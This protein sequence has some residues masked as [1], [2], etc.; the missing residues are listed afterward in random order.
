MKMFVCNYAIS[1][2]RPYR[3]TGEFINVGVVLVCPQLDYFNFAFERRKHRRIT[4]FFPELDIEIFKT[5]LAGLLSELTRLAKLKDAAAQ[6][7][8]GEEMAARMALF[9]ELVRPRENLFHFGEVGTAFTEDPKTKLK[10]L[11]DIYVRRQFAQDHEYQEIVMRR[12]LAVFL[13]DA[14]LSRFYRQ[15]FSVGDGSYNVR[16]PFVH[17]EANVP[18]KA[19][20][21]L[22]LDKPSPTE[23]YR[24][25]DAWISTVRRLRQI[26][27]LP[28]ELLFAVQRPTVGERLLCAAEEVCS[29]LEKLETFTAAVADRSRI[30]AFARFES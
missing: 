24:H 18:I 20:K 17:L 3:E 7:V 6:F 1:R 22:N 27:H 23:I 12:Q 11:Y 28:K 4:E 10:E 8:F 9:K 16:L 15:N 29:E 26:N 2:F 19:I 13:H 30:E 25:G 21:P 14:N 5:G